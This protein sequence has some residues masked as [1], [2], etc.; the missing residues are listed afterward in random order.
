MLHPY[1]VRCEVGQ[2]DDDL[3]EIL[4]QSKNP[5]V[6]Q[7]HLKML[8]AGIHKV[9]GGRILLAYEIPGWGARVSV[10]ICHEA[11]GPLPPPSRPCPARLSPL[12]SRSVLTTPPSEQCSP[13]RTK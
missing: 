1:L 6:I 7:S 10:I 12:R 8:F 13:W 9:W 11:A 2:S 4:G 3:L 5:A